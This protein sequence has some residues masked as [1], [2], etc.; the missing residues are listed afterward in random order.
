MTVP[1]ERWQVGP[2][3]RWA[4]QHVSEVVATARVP[5]GDGA[6]RGLPERPIGL[7][8]AASDLEAAFVDGVAV[9]ADGALVLERYCNGM[10]PDTLHLS[11]SVAKSV[12]GLLVGALA[13]RGA[14]DP[15]T[16]VT[17][18]VP[19]VAGS[20][21][22]GATVRHLLDMTAAI[23]FV[24]DYA[25]DFWKY[26]V[27]CGWHP[28]R[29]GA[30][31]GSILEYLPAIGAA[32]WGH[33]ERFHYASPNTDLLGLVAERAGGA[34]LAELIAHELWGPLG[35][36]RDAELAIDPAGTA[37]ISGGFCA[38][39]RDYVRLGLLVLA[40]GGD[41][42]PAGWIAHLGRGDERAF[43]RRDRPDAGGGAAG[44]GNQWW[45][46]DGG[47]AARGIHG[48]LVAVHGDTRTVVAILSSWPDAT[49]PALD[50]RQR[51]F[52]RRAQLAAAAP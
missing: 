43:R 32:G 30:E 33:G 14:L 9:V 41:V 10:G 40:N 39:L 26:D 36:E 35:A 50:A 23:D 5:R 34:P 6:A 48:Q 52:V 13:G 18:H 17:K 31:A 29:P 20:G 46:G 44:Y 27:A 51:A 4:Y 21:Y 37:V 15:M 49:D 22:A 47:L 1:L 16:P 25:A 38:T 45:S 3:N 19:E 11:Q 8:T 24:E 42:V 28:P 7:G 12:L 2:W